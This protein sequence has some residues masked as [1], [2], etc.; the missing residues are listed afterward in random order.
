MSSIEGKRPIRPHKDVSSHTAADKFPRELLNIGGVIGDLVRFMRETA[1]SPQPVLA[2]GASLVLVGTLAG[3]KYRTRNLRTNVY[4]IGI[5]DSGGGKDHARVVIREALFAAGLGDY[6]GGG[7]LASGVGLLASLEKHP[8]RLFPLDEVGV[9]IQSVT[10]RKAA[11]WRKHIWKLLIELYTSASGVFL[12]TEY[13]DQKLRPRVDIQQPCCCVYGVSVPGEFWSALNSGCLTN[14]SLARFLLF[15]TDDDYPDRQPNAE[16]GEIPVHI[17]AGLQAIVAGCED[18]PAGN[19]SMVASASPTPYDVPE[20]DD[21]K[22]ARILISDEQQDW[23]RTKRGTNHTAVVAR[24]A[25][26]VNKVALI[27][28]ISDCAAKPVMTA[29]HFQWAATLVRHCITIMLREAEYNIGATENENNLNKVLNFLR[30]HEG[31]ATKSDIAKGVRGPKGKDRDAL[32]KDMV[33]NGMLVVEPFGTT[34]RG[35][36][37]VIPSVH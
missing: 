31:K 35:E 32:L 12:G 20:T 33:D 9:F 25:E 23:L 37:Y 21:A 18:A 1:I 8:S 15:L 16:I 11:Q 29:D 6:L 36:I 19:L 3:R 13:G 28:A 14:G 22:K 27:L 5:A 10:D 4:A 34:K 2:L 7:E 17:V 24:F 30:K 26:N